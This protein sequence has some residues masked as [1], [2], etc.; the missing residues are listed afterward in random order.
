[1]FYVEKVTAME[2]VLQPVFERGFAGSGSRTQ[3]F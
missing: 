2:A 1:M 3:Q